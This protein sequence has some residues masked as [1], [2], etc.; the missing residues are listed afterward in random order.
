MLKRI[1]STLLFMAGF[2][3]G[4]AMAV[5]CQRAATPLDNTICNNDTLHWLDSTMDMI[6]HSMLV[7]NNAAQVHKD[8]LE[9]DKSLES[10]TSDGCIERAYYEGISRISGVQEDF[11]WQGNWWNT[12]AANRSGGNITLSRNAEWSL[13]VDIR[14]WAGANHDDFTAEARKIY[15]MAIVEKVK[16]TSNCK[17]LFIPRQDG[18]IQVHSN[19]DWGCKLSMPKGV[20]IDGRYVKSQT[21]PR[22]K[23]TL[24]SIGVFPDAATDTRFRAMVGDDYQ[25]FVDAA[26]VYIYQDDIDNIGAKVIS[27]WV[28]GEANRHTAIVMYTSDG[29][30]WAARTSPGKNGIQEAKFYRSKGNETGPLPRTLQGWKLR[31]L[32]K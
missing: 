29:K 10:C 5:D 28:R 18:S 1:L 30:M 11:D 9:W 27:M 15:G 20:F 24:L 23:A 21:D 26:N 16:D 17:L 12:T 13:T 19:A 14:A 25:N 22:P 7:K 4:N 3:A 2:Y 8:Y 31:F 6:Y 32:D